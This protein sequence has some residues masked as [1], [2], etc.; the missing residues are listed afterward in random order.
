MS[1]KMKLDT[2]DFDVL[3]KKLN[4]LD[5]DTKRIA[6]DALKAGFKHVQNN[7]NKVYK[8]SNM[9]AQGEYSHGETEQYIIRSGTV[10]WNNTVA[11]I[12]VGFSLSGRG[13]VAQFLTYGT[14]V[15][16]TPRMKPMRGLKAA[17]KGK[18]TLDGVRR[19]EEEVFMKAIREL[20]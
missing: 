12:G 9:P 18:H 5:A 7:V 14:E 11:E 4:E 13:L 17:I 16:G 8:A 3:I 20:E 2:S 15:N 10:Q 1:T 6:E 19:V